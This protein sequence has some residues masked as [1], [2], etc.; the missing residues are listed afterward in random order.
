M[1]EFCGDQGRALQRVGGVLQ[2]LFGEGLHG[3]V[4]QRSDACRNFC[5]F[6]NPEAAVGKIVRRIAPPAG[7]QQGVL[8]DRQSPGDR[9]RTHPVTRRE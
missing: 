9:S 3:H 5:H 7:A 1:Q 8:N 6:S 4:F 2:D